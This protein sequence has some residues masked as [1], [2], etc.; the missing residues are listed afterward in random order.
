[1]QMAG[2]TKAQS[3]NEEV[4]FYVPQFAIYISASV[5][6]VL[7]I[8]TWGM[9]QKQVFKTRFQQELRLLTVLGYCLASRDT[10]K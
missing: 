5:G 8:H 10:S 7:K 1:M 4:G 9:K 6:T 2:S 3:N